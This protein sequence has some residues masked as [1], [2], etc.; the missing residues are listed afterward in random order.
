[1]QAQPGVAASQDNR[2]DLL[3]RGGGAIENQTRI[4]GFDG[5]GTY[6]DSD[7]DEATDEAGRLYAFDAKPTPFNSYPLVFIRSKKPTEGGVANA[8]DAVLDLMGA[9]RLEDRRGHVDQGSAL[10]LTARPDVGSPGDENAVGAVAA[11]D[12]DLGQLAGRQLAGR[13]CAPV[14]A[15]GLEHVRV[16]R[17]HEEVGEAFQV[18][19]V[20]Q[21][22]PPPYSTNRAG[23]GR[24]VG[25]CRHGRA[26]L[27]ARRRG[28]AAR[29][30]SR[31]RR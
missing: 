20:E 22:F 27:S 2:N 30:R 12:G 10:H 29:S 14:G 13:V 17:L 23:A 18:G 16:F 28:R 6:V 3:V 5:T 1:M 21:L 4:D 8:R 24:G 9:G 25:V 31:G 15:V 7:L 26:V 19:T 11:G